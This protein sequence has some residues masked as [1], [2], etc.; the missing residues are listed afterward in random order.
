MITYALNLLSCE[1]GLNWRLLSWGLIPI[2]QTACHR[3]QE[4]YWHA[5]F[6][7]R[8]DFIHRGRPWSGSKQESLEVMEKLHFSFIEQGFCLGIWTGWIDGP[9][10]IV[11]DSTRPS[12]GSCTLGTTTPCNTK[13]GWK[14]AQWKRTLGCWLTAGWTWAIRVPRWP[15]TPMVSR[16]VPA[17]VWLAGAERGSCPCTW[18]WWGCTSST[19]FSSLQGGH[20]GAGVCPGKSNG[21]GEGSRTEVLWGVAEGDEAV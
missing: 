12:A 3:M 10:S 14:A 19:V 5:G 7:H 16:L 18:H 15:R 1:T 11:W 6:G 2:K 21:A 17:I 9:M 8:I 13:S 4:I 20:W